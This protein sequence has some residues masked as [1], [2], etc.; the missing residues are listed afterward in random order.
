MRDVITDLIYRQYSHGGVG[1]NVFDEP[2][3][4]KLG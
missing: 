3:Y 4:S 2:A 1:K